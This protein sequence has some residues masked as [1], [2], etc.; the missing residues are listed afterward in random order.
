MKLTCKRL[1]ATEIG[2]ELSSTL[3]GSRI[4]LNMMRL[5]TEQTGELNG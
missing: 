1:Q 5:F 3:T 4:V 2:A